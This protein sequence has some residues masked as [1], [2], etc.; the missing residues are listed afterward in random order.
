MSFWKSASSPTFFQRWHLD[1]EKVHIASGSLLSP[2]YVSPWLLLTHRWSV[3]PCACS[4]GIGPCLPCIHFRSVPRCCNSW[5]L[6]GWPLGTV[7]TWFPHITALVPVQLFLMV[8]TVRDS[9]VTSL[10]TM[11]ILSATAH[12]VLGLLLNVSRAHE[13]EHSITETQALSLLHKD[14]SKSLFSSHLNRCYL[15]FLS[16]GSPYIMSSLEFFIL[17]LTPFS[18]LGM[19][20]F[21]TEV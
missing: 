1:K 20:V 7:K 14:L 9:A 21:M 12:L 3:A 16:E 5:E 6:M 4:L 15:L 13:R 8:Q 19:R 17:R 10:L 2:Y 11:A 18:S